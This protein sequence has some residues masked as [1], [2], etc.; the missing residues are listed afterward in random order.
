MDK[1]WVYLSFQ[2]SGINAQIYNSWVVH[3]C[4]FSFMKELPKYFPEW[5]KHFTFPL[6]M[7]RQVILFLFLFTRI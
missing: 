6:A 3:Y 4:I 7:D 5:L 2:F 1:L